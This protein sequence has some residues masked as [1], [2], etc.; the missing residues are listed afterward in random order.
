MYFDFD[1]Y[2]VKD[3]YRPLID[4]FAKS[5]AADRAKRLQVEGHT[6]DQGGR[7][8]N[9][10]L[11]Q[12]RAEAV[13]KSLALLGAANTQVEAV[14]FGKERPAATRDR[15][16]RAREEPPR[17]AELPVRRHRPCTS[18]LRASYRATAACC[19][20]LGTLRCVLRRRTRACSTT[21]KRAARSSTSA[22]RSSRAQPTS[23]PAS[24]SS[25]IRSTSC[26]RSLL[27]LNNQLEQ[28]RAD[29]A[30]LRGQNE[31]LARDLSE[32]QRKQ[33]D[34]QSGVDDRLRK[35][36]PQ[37]VSLEG[38]KRLHASIPTRSAST[39]KRWNC[40]A[41]AISPA[42]RTRSRR[43]ASAG[44]RSGYTESALFWLGNAQYGV[45][46]YKEA[47]ASFRAHVSG[48]FAGQRQSTRGAA[49][50]REL[51]GRAERRQGLRERP[52]T[53]CSRRTR[54]PRPLRLDAS[55]SRR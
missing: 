31:Q 35:F 39:T 9:L 12:K 43:F 2:V 22:R 21:T 45:R 1:S 38:G 5:L 16:R 36:E 3:D 44:R 51:P 46:Q 28:V 14:S 52:S 55:D 19:A 49:R 27:D 30:K 8:Y 47:I 6:D 40:C 50:D 7:E 26:K 53:S 41:R 4:R 17:R 13:A 23:G 15:R 24:N 29:N 25:P 10:A 37:K 34:I 54:S 11:G 18:H 32:V 20:E 42:P 48:R 33:K